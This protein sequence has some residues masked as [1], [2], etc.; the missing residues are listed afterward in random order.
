MHGVGL[1]QAQQYLL[2]RC[3]VFPNAGCG[4]VV[5]M[6]VCLTACTDDLYIPC[7][8][9]TKDHSGNMVWVANTDV[10]LATV[11]SRTYSACQFAGG[12]YLSVP[13]FK[14]NDLGDNWTIK[15]NYQSTSVAGTRVLVS[16]SLCSGVSPSVEVTH[17]G[18]KVCVNLQTTGGP[19]TLC[20]A[21][22]VSMPW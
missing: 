12:A 8:V 7:A 3:S 10:T 6:Y 19:V 2:S 16:N 11:L 14:N 9:D 4:D 21:N 1:T 18:K 15:F 20:A 17:K 22:T 5:H 13:F